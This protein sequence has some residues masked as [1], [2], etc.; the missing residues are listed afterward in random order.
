RDM[1]AV[2][3]WSGARPAGAGHATRDRI[4]AG[5]R[6]G[7]PRD[8][9]D[10]GGRECARDALPVLE[11]LCGAATNASLVVWRRSGVG[12]IRVG[13]GDGPASGGRAIRR[14]ADDGYRLDAVAGVAAADGQRVGTLV[15]QPRSPYVSEWEADDSAIT[16]R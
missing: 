10:R 6:H 8:K 9:V 7:S 16:C 15:A 11:R 4:G 14:D 5:A 13:V 2:A 3:P 12:R 1:V